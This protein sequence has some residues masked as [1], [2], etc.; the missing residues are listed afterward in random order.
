MWVSPRTTKLSRVIT[1]T[2]FLEP[3]HNRSR[4][5]L[6]IQKRD[7]KLLEHLMSQALHFSALT[8][9]YVLD[10]N[11]NRPMSHVGFMDFLKNH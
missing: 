3:P 1:A 6:A 2:S 7:A 8:S 9:L 4:M 5:R 10:L 11:A